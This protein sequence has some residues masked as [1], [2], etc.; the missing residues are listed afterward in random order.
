MEHTSHGPVDS[1]NGRK[2]KSESE[3]GKLIRPLRHVMLRIFHKS[4]L[5]IG[6]NLNYAYFCR[7]DAFGDKLYHLFGLHNTIITIV[8][9]RVTL[10][11]LDP[12]SRKRHNT[13]IE[14]TVKMQ[15]LLITR[16]GSRYICLASKRQELYIIFHEK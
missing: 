10:S 1:K 13:V 15:F 9:Y 6:T 3:R 5:I 2:R 4:L 11:I 14:N 8:I 16:Y 12:L 7:M